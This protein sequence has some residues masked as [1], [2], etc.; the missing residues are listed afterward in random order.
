MPVEIRFCGIVVS[1]TGL[2]EPCSTDEGSTELELIVVEF[3]YQLRNWN[4]LNWVNN[5]D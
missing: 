2:C 5:T 1:T 3:L 4:A